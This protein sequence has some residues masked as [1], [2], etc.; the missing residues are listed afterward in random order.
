MRA[1]REE[2]GRV[3]REDHEPPCATER[4]GWRYHHTGIPTREV[5][6]D[7]RYLAEFK[8]YVSGFPDSPFGVEWM[9]FEPG[10]PVP[11]VVRTMP[12]VAFEVDDLDAALADKEVVSAPG[13]PS[14]GVRAAM[15]LDDG[16]PI[17]LIEFG[18]PKPAHAPRASRGSGG[19]TGA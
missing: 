8:V 16:C 12:H 10:S 17:E 18:G 5:R 6:P 9:R 2:G 11:E 3:K 1:F 15:I 7:E 14:T 13:S 4:W 19:R